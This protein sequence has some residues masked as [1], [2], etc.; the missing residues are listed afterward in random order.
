[1]M[2]SHYVAIDFGTSGSCVAFATKDLS[3]I[4]V[5]S[6]WSKNV[7]HTGAS[8]KVPTIVLL[9]PTQNL[10]AVGEDALYFYQKKAVKKK[11]EFDQYYLFNRFKM[12]LYSET[13]EQVRTCKYSLLGETIIAQNVI[14]LSLQ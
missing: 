10:E 7:R 9:D 6:D 4:H 5:L 1:M 3:N 11:G 2:A 13:P 12:S 14:P 8:V